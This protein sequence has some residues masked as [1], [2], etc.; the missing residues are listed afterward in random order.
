MSEG[1]LRGIVVAHGAMADG[2][3]D[4]VQ[5]IAGIEEGVL[6]A[7][8]NRGLSPQAL[9]DRVRDATSGHESI[10]FTDLPSGSCGSAARMLIRNTSGVGVVCGVNLAMLLD[11]VTHRHLSVDA[12]LERLVTKARDSIQSVATPVPQHGDT[13]VQG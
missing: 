3:V 6:V 11:F 2:L 4:A 12:L 7:V 8:S 10:V 13:A 5:S 9:A 1:G